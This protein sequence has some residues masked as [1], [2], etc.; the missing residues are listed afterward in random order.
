MTISVGCPT[1][2]R[3]YDVKGRLAGKKVRCTDCAT[4]FRVPVP[5]TMPV[6]EPRR[7]KRRTEPV[8]GDPL[9]ELLDSASMSSLAPPA[10][11]SRQIGVPG[12]PGE[13]RGYRAFPWIA[14]AIPVAFWVL[15]WGSP[16]R[17][18]ILLCVLIGVFLLLP[19]MANWK[20]FERTRRARW[21][22]AVIGLEGAKAVQA[23][24]AIALWVL[25][26]LIGMDTI[27]IHALQAP[28]QV[29]PEA[30]AKPV[31]PKPPAQE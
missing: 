3:R 4:T 13:R 7:R 9:A 12:D 8:V 27:H 23:T 25:A 26:L 28:Q 17:M 5:V 22:G 19:I 20:S 15:G 21:I 29:P 14:V 18:T 31:L 1:C 6:D 2:G 10:A 16:L 24:V 11:G 30:T